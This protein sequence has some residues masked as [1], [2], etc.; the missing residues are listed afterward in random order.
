MNRRAFLYG[1]AGCA[2][3]LPGRS[4]AQSLPGYSLFPGHS[5]NRARAWRIIPSIVVVSSEDDFRIPLVSEA[6]N[7]WNDE[8]AKLKISFRLGSVTHVVGTIP[9]QDIQAI[10]AWRGPRS[11]PPDLPDSVRQAEGDVVIA[12]SDGNFISFAFR[13]PSVP[14]A[15]AAIQRLT[16]PGVVDQQA[17]TAIQR[18]ALVNLARYAIAHELGHVIGL[19]HN[20]EAGKLMC[21]APAACWQSTYMLGGWEPNGLTETEKM[22]L[23]LMY[24]PRLAG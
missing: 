24:P 2:T 13:W 20:S 12:L 10:R 9:F 3:G 14:K 16:H 17:L 4:H 21:G 15:L 19:G 18:L 7:F 8:L 6:V 23:L 11:Q 22:D 5:P 1:L